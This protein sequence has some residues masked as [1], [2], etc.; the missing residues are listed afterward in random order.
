[1]SEPLNSNQHFDAVV[2]RIIHTLFKGA[3][4]LLALLLA[5]LA[6]PVQ[7]NLSLGTD[8]NDLD[9]GHMQLRARNS[10]TVTKT[11]AQRSELN[12]DITANIATVTLT[13]HFVHSG[14]DWVEGEYVFPLPENAIIKNMQLK[15]GERIIN[16]RI[17]EKAEAK[18]IYQQAKAQGKKAALV[19]QHRPNLFRT[20]VANIAPGETIAVTLVYRQLADFNNGRFSLRFPMTITPRYNPINTI[21]PVAMPL[22]QNA[23]ANKLL[24]PI[25]IHGS[26]L[27]GFV[28]ESISGGQH[29]LALSREGE[30]YQFT[31][32]AGEV[33][34]DR[35]FELSW[36]AKPSEK[37]LASVIT[38]TVGDEHYSLLMLLPPA[39][40]TQTE[41]PREVIFVIDVS[42]S[43][44]GTSIQQARAALLRGLSKMSPSD[45]FN[46][47]SFSDSTDSL[48]SRPAPADA[49]AI[50]QAEKF[51]RNL[52]A[53]GGTEM[54]GAL[55]L[56]LSQTQA[57]TQTEAEALKQL[58][59]ITD[60]AV[61]NEQALFSM[62]DQHLAE[63]RLFT[64][65]I[66]SAPNSWFMREAAELGRGQFVFISDLEQVATR[67]E[68][69][70]TDIGRPLS[71]DVQINWP[72]THSAVQYPNPIPDLYAGAPV[73]AVM[74]SSEP[75]T[76]GQ[77]IT[78]SGR[79]ASET[80]QRQVTVSQAGTGAGVADLWVRAHIDELLDQ[81]YRGGDM[82][83]IRS[84]VTA[85][86]L[87]HQLL[88]PYT[89]FVA[90]E[91]TPSRQ[92]QEKL[93][94]AIVRNTTPHGQ[95]AW[96]STATSAEV[97]LWL[98]MAGLLLG[99]ISFVMSREEESDVRQ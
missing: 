89:A 6:L 61:G 81:R 74:R 84:E 46:I 99:L 82:N 41:L 24:N 94:K 60:G 1:M 98:G 32:A 56:A 97:K 64:V 96:P 44:A 69:L 12:L 2:E 48:F 10:G 11:L 20:K 40:K 35:D 72:Q 57:Q 76:E 63:R 3:C 31:L 23:G 55:T 66:G 87:N 77:Q 8:F 19:Q 91:E 5:S 52:E 22:P 17:R 42:G 65:G 29:T 83:R 75:L 80:W 88:S 93:G 16:G 37:P 58:I 26:L 36:L 67:M 85:L 79:L 59:F 4:A 86:S 47:I 14:N 54:A 68:K 39:Q 13:Q 92:A 62:I 27:P 18:K 45:R 28:P 49:A 15:V 73:L 51:V 34:M 38:E 50:A 53:N 70:L 25:S 9:A 7:A 90:V 95:T 30:R 43:M 33:E 71:R 78:M 21:N